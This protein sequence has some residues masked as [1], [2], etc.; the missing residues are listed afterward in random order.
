MEEGFSHHKAFLKDLWVLHFKLWVLNNYSFHWL[1]NAKF[2][3]CRTY[4]VENTSFG[5]FCLLNLVI[6]TIVTVCSCHVTYVFQCESTLYS[7]VN[8]KELLAQSRRKIWRLSDCNWTRTQNH[9][10]CKRTLN[11]FANY[12]I[13]IYSETTAWH[14]K[15]IQSNA[16]YR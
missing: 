1:G 11:H 10:V 13:W 3:C 8:V 12:R 2:P 7:C 4:P 14:D 16:P 15:N 5:S 9:L 6:I